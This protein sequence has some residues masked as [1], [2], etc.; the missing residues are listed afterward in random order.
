MAITSLVGIHWINWV[1]KLIKHFYSLFSL[2][3]LHGTQK[4]YDAVYIAYTNHIQRF[5]SSIITGD[6]IDSLLSPTNIFLSLVCEGSQRTQLSL[7][8]EK[9]RTSPLWGPC[10]YPGRGTCCDISEI[11]WKTWA[12][13]KREGTFMKWLSQKGACDS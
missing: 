1:N 13:E 10:C 2:Q 7:D 6:K 11:K 3:F 9:L 5:Y 8:T 12:Q 4:N